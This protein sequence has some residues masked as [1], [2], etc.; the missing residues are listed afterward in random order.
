MRVRLLFT[1]SSTPVRSVGYGDFLKEIKTQIRPHQYLA[2]RA[3]NRKL[4]ALYWWLGENISRRQAE[5][6]W[7]K[8]VV[9]TLARDLQAD[10]PGRNG[11]SAQNLWLMRQFHQAAPNP[12]CSWRE[13]A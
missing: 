8:A 7:G 6:G 9:E 13:Q 2:L 12:G 3:A 11:L 5:L 10:F 1:R 4:L